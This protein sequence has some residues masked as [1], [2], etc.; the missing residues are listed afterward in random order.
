MEYLKINSNR[1]RYLLYIIIVLIPFLSTCDGG[2]NTSTSG[3]GSISLNIIWSDQIS[4]ILEL[5]S[6][7]AAHID[8]NDLGVETTQIIV[9]DQEGNHVK[10]STLWPCENHM[11][12]LHD[13][14]A[15]SN[16]TVVVLFRES[17][18]ANASIFL[19]G[20][21]SD[22][23]KVPNAGT[24]NVT[25]EVKPFVPEPSSPSGISIDCGGSSL[26]WVPVTDAAGYTI[27]ISENS[28]MTD[29][30]NYEITDAH[31]TPA[32]IIESTT[33]YWQVKA[34]DAFGN[35]SSRTAIRSYTGSDTGILADI[36]DSESFPS[37]LTEASGKLFFGA[38]DG[39]NG[40]ELW[41]SD[42]TASGTR[43][44]ADINPGPG[45]SNPSNITYYKGKLFFSGTIDGT[46]IELLEYE[47]GSL[48]ASEIE[49]NSTS[50][51]YPSELVVSDDTLYFRAIGESGPSLWKF[52][53]S[54]LT[55]VTQAMCGNSLT[56][57]YGVLY[58]SCT[59]GY[60]NTDLHYYDGKVV[61]PIPIN[62]AN[63][64]IKH[65]DA[66]TAVR[67]N[68][69]FRT[70]LDTGE[71]HLWYFNGT[72]PQKI[73]I[74]DSG[75]SDPSL[76]TSHL[77]QVNGSLCFIAFDGSQYNLYEHDGIS[78]SMIA[79]GGS[80]YF[81][82]LYS[83]NDTLFI[84]LIDGS[85]DTHPMQLW[86]KE[87]GKSIAAM[88]KELGIPDYYFYYPYKALGLN[89]KFYFSLYLSDSDI[90]N[91]EIGG[92]EIWESDGTEE[93]TVLL[94]ETKND[95]IEMLYYLPEMET[96]G[97]ALYFVHD[98]TQNGAGLWKHCP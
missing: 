7:A 47:D 94:A 62:D 63:I 38:N 17:S 50:S 61:N 29:A 83:V 93:N 64:I 75:S 85:K 6:V 44:A 56:D 59:D 40:F 26:E 67:D 39:I 68:V 25:I 48:S 79:D 3:G 2:S 98:A 15:G 5:R 27:S 49:I 54:N 1:K 89:N 55:Q 20:M 51:S 16:Y 34:K 87:S 60:G 65:I 53:G 8:C 82:G 4:R 96:A 24:V 18:E 90:P 10:N 81:R 13:V 76:L 37:Q 23:I 91:G 73:E 43:M 35:Q 57:N 95:N 70:T 11:G 14:R 97:G 78:L 66:I 19:H 72:T 52:D 12:T 9:Y 28:D 86:Q 21:T 41:E 92:A 80:K 58:F 77:T 31:Y 69:Y 88:V 42:G 84:L 71:T 36:N 32:D 74:N 33:Y 46:D 45:G 30:T 22:G